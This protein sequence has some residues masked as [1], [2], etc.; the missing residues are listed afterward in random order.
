MKEASK[1][2]LLNLVFSGLACKLFWG[3]F[4]C[5]GSFHV[6]LSQNFCSPIQW[7]CI[8]LHDI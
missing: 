3:D 5:Q 6:P 1:Y 2:S 4:E 7:P 8:A